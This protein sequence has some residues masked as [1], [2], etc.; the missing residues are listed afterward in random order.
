MD[1]ATLQRRL[2]ALGLDPGPDDGTMGP[3]TRAAVMLA[4]TNRHAPA[5]TDADIASVAAE[6]RVPVNHINGVR[7]VEAPRGPFD[8]HGR[9]SILYEP[10]VFSRQSEHRFDARYP[11]LSYR[12]WRSGQYG[13]FSAQYPKL[14]DACALD[15]GAAFKAC[16]WGA[17]QV[18]GENAEDLGYR[19]AFAMAVALS[20][21][22][23]DHLESFVRFIRW[24][25]LE[26][27][28]RACRPGNPKSCEPFVAVYN[29][30]GQVPKY[31]AALAK[32]IR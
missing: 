3:K 20:K 15:P 21:S 11:T 27:E 5:L 8:D 12:S 4:L 19:D 32:A 30:T 18:L 13:P 24:K 7:I 10:H 17:F 31:S 29:G 14:L 23:A 28:L 26:D 1:V 9:P 25:K 6:L 2:M 16:S 22:E